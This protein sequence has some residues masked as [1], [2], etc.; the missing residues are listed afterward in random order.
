MSSDKDLHQDQL[1]REQTPIWIQASEGTS[2]KE[3]MGRVIKIPDLKQYS[4]S[5]TVLYPFGEK[6]DE[7]K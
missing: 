4:K 3:M 5:V 6:D 7:N 1:P 2:Q